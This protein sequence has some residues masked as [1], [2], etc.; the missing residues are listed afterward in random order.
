[1]LG[2]P[3]KDNCFHEARIGHNA[4]LFSGRYTVLVSFILLVFV[5]CLQPSP[6]GPLLFYFILLFSLPQQIIFVQCQGTGVSFE[7]NVVVTKQD[8]SVGRISGFVEFDISG[9]HLTCGLTFHRH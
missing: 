5:C 6:P 2:S 8:R 3:F 1:M 7:R 4:P 9:M